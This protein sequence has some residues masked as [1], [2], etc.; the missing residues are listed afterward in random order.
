LQ[1]LASFCVWIAGFFGNTV[2]W[3]GRRY[4]LHPDGTFELLQSRLE[5]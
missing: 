1:D 2:T 3:R 5:S 4:Y